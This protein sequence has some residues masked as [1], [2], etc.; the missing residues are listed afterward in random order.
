MAP[1]KGTKNPKNPNSNLFRRLTRIFSGPIIDYR[2]QTI[3]KYR[4]SQLDK[5]AQTFRSLSGQQFKKSSYNPFHNLQSNIISSQN[6]VE[7]YA[8][9]D[10]MEYT[11]EIASALDIYADEM[12]TSSDLQPLLRIDCTN[13]EIKTVLHTLYHNIL[14]IE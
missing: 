6:R 9:F 4:R 5:F 12:T 3:R 2:A 13:E 10:Q 7:R 1:K 14:N 8:D 11:P